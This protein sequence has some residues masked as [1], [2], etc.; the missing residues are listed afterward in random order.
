MVFL[1]NK[2]WKKEDDMWN[3]S[4]YKKTAVAIGSI[5]G[6]K[7]VDVSSSWVEPIKE[8]SFD[9]QIATIGIK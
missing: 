3:H 7:V 8:I 5:L 9:Y 6:N 2:P 4:G 1:Q